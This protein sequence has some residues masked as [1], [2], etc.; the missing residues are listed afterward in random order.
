MNEEATEP[1]HVSSAAPK[2]RRSA[3]TG[4]TSPSPPL[5]SS[6]RRT[7]TKTYDVYVRDM[8]VPL[9]A[10]RKSS[11][12]YTLVSAKNG[13]EEPASI[14]A[15]GTAATGPRTRAPK[16]GRTPRSPPTAAT[17]LFRTPVKLASNLPERRRGGHPAAQ[18]FVRDLQAE[19][20]HSVSTAAGT[21]RW[22]T[23]QKAS[24]PAARSVRPRSARMARPSPGW[25]PTRP[26]QT[27]FLCGESL[28]NRRALLPVAA[29]A[30]TESGHPACHRYRR[31][32]R[33][34]VSARR[35]SRR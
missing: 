19:D 17:S 20:D 15:E 10:D 7:T 14:R 33:P 28:N 9:S 29:L 4:A 30:G 13:G 25:P 31:S 24:P 2:T 32:R 11:G 3:P 16:C 23:R 6:R 21:K 27:R 22:R 35:G 1:A 12:A 8:D 5:S 26:S 18:L 34:R